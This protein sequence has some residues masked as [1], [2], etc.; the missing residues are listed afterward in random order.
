VHRPC[1]WRGD[2]ISSYVIIAYVKLA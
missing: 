1:S 2:L